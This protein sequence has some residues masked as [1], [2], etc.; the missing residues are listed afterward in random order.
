MVHHLPDRRKQE[1]FGEIRGRL[2]PGGWY[3]NYE[4]VAA[5]DPLVEEAWL[6]ANDR[7]DPT[8]A[9]KR[10]HR[11]QEEQLRYENHVRYMIPLTP[12][13]EFLADAGFEAI[14]VYWK[15]LDYAIYGGRK[16]LSRGS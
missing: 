7:Q 12:Q 8:A 14:D 6:R 9:E 4:A 10:A 16:P 2:A 13:L 11:T 15:S 1:L 5:G 3:L